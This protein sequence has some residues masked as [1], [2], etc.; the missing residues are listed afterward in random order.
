M[1]LYKIWILKEGVEIGIL[2]ASATKSILK[3][4]EEAYQVA[5]K[6]EAKLLRVE[7]LEHEKTKSMM[8]G[9]YID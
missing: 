7:V 4:L 8:E 3:V 5:G 9:T 2:H 6:L 1:N